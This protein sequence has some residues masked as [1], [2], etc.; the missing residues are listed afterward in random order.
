[1]GNVYTIQSV[2][3]YNFSYHLQDP[4]VDHANEGGVFSSLQ[5]RCWGGS[6]DN[7]IILP[8]NLS[9]LTFQS[10]LVC[11]VLHCH[12]IADQM[13]SVFSSKDKGMLFPVLAVR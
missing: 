11:A 10:S 3:I 6:R 4:P 5:T 2:I 8:Q 12:N 9:H 1:M 13:N 7:L